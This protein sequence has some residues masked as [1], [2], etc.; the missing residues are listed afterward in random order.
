VARTA[1]GALGRWPF[2]QPSMMRMRSPTTGAAASGCLGT[3]PL[4]T[5]S[6][7]ASVARRPMVRFRK[8]PGS[9]SRTAWFADASTGS[10]SET[11]PTAAASHAATSGIVGTSGGARRSRR[12]TTLL[13][14]KTTTQPS[15]KPSRGRGTCTR[16]ERCSTRAKSAASPALIQDRRLPR[17]RG[18]SRRTERGVP[19]PS[20]S[21]REDR[22]VPTWTGRHGHLRPA[23]TT[24]RP[25]SVLPP[26]S[27]DP[28]AFR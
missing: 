22:N 17:K 4:R 24:E 21:S 8:E 9:R 2:T 14:L 7:T 3:A 27:M 16:S 6:V 13:S 18:S 19:I 11:V 5:S 1:A 20:R 10:E 15:S 12:S 25:H 23:G 28:G 26:I